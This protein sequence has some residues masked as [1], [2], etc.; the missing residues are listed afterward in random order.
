MADP[1]EL[2]PRFP[3]SAR[4]LLWVTYLGV[5]GLVGFYLWTGWDA[6][7]AAGWQLA[8][9]L[10]WGGSTL[11]AAAA[12]AW[13]RAGSGIGADLLA[14][15]RAEPWAKWIMVDQ[16]VLKLFLGLLMLRDARMRGRGIWPYMVGLIVVGAAAPLWYFASPLR[17]VTSGWSHQARPASTA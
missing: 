3:R 8:N 12:R 17:R 2:M 5:P 11:A 15:Y 7:R 16:A 9:P 6:A 13:A 4:A 14:F 10:V 1:V